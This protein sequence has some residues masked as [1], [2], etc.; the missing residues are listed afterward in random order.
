MSKLKV[1]LRCFTDV[2][3]L[4]CKYNTKHA[5]SLQEMLHEKTQ[6]FFYPLI[7][8]IIFEE[9]FDKNITKEIKKTTFL[10]I[11]KIREINRMNYAVSYYVKNI[12]KNKR[13]KDFGLIIKN[14]YI[15]KENEYKLMFNVKNKNSQMRCFRI[16]KKLYDDALELCTDL[17]IEL[18]HL[19]FVACETLVWDLRLKNTDTDLFNK[20][21]AAQFN[22]RPKNTNHSKHIN[23]T[24]KN[25]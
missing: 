24:K 22:A 1:E 7:N 25:I 3:N 20:S 14:E 4:A 17:D 11:L 19:Y 13:N 10:R 12:S 9:Y 6:K 23:L 16:T 5:I 8:L 2:C 18:K 21:L 15:K